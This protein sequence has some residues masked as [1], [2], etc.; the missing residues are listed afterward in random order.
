MVQTSAATAAVGGEAKV[1]SMPGTFDQKECIGN[2]VASNAASPRHERGVKNVSTPFP[3]SISA[4][5]MAT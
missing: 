3:L 5:R 2:T 4:K 1:A